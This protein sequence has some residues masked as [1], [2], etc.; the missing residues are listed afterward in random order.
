MKLLLPLLIV[1]TGCASYTPIWRGSDLHASEGS[2]V[3]ITGKPV[4][5]ILGESL[6]YLCPPTHTGEASGKCID[7]LA[8]TKVVTELRDSSAQCATV[9][10]TFRAFG[11]ERIGMGNFRSD[12]GYIEAAR[13]GSCHER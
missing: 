3:Q 11:P 5:S 9:S 1:L 6:L 13:V 2:S 12:L 8:P 7:I 4:F 10:G